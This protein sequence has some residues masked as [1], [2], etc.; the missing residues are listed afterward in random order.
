MS[1]STAAPKLDRLQEELRNTPEALARYAVIE[2]QC[3]QNIL[4]ALAGL[5]TTADI[6]NLLRGSVGPLSVI[7]HGLAAPHPLFA[8]A[9][10]IPQSFVFGHRSLTFPHLIIIYLQC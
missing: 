7:V 5:N 8:T 1:V 9:V 6:R 2:N 3:I 4:P 10:T